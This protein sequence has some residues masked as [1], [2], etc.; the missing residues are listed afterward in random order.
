VAKTKSDKNDDNEESETDIL[1]EDDAMDTN[2]VNASPNDKGDTKRAGKP[3]NDDEKVEA[4]KNVEDSDIV[5]QDG[6][7][8]KSKLEGTSILYH[9]LLMKKLEKRNWKE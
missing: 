6:A 7:V 5:N 3:Q 4:E 1:D 8:E 2:D 9:Y